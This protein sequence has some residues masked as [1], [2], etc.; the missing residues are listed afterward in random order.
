MTILPSVKYCSTTGEIGR[1]SKSKSPNYRKNG[2]KSLR[3]T[4]LMD[5]ILSVN[6]P[7]DPILCIFSQSY[8]PIR[9]TNCSNRLRSHK[10]TD[11]S[12]HGDSIYKHDLSHD[13][14]L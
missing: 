11:L 10:S 7:R 14:P 2:D 5:V 1:I 12:L 3:V 13:N 8:F 6:R 9:K 4:N